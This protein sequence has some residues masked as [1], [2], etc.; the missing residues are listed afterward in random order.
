MAERRVVFLVFDGVTMLDVSG[1][2][3]VLAAATRRGAAYTPL[4][5]SPDGAPVTTS[6]GAPLPVHTAAGDVPEPVDTVVVAGGDDLVDRPM[7][8]GLVAAAALLHGRAR[9]TVAVCTGAFVLADAGILRGRRAT[10]HWR[11]ADLLARAHP[12]VRVL[13]DAI[14]V[15]DG[16][17]HTSA[18]VSAGIDLALSLVEHDHGPDLA[19]EVARHLVV[20]MQ[21]P[22]GQSQFSAPL[23][24]P[25]VRAPHLRAVVEAVG[26]D[27]AGDHSV[28][29]LAAR[30]GVS[31]RQLGRLFAAELG[32]TP[33]RFVERMRID[34]AKALLDGGRGVT[35]TARL[36]GFGSDETLRRVF[37]E[38]L[39][40]SP[41]RYR[42]RFGGSLA[43]R[44]DQGP[45]SG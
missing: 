36:A 29:A 6:I 10:T 45:S 28:A 44:P 18:G 19:R 42:S 39:G 20:F 15:S 43:P 3:E 2:A 27:P 4:Y 21:R 40:V 23:R 24:T 13:P 11:H 22:G 26:A 5:A 30:A 35:E 16:G 1:P 41:G 34:A 31:R 8:P 38:R 12:D 37:T 9:R 7:P 32:T 33:A 14:F 17:V 25:P